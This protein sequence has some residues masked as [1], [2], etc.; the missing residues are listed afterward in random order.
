[1]TENNDGLVELPDGTRIPDRRK[2]PKPRVLQR[3]AAEPLASIAIG[4]TLAVLAW[5]TITS[6]TRNAQEA[7]NASINAQAASENAQAARNLSELIKAAQ[8]GLARI[9][10]ASRKTTFN[11]H[12][13]MQDTLVCIL[14]IQPENRTPP[15]IASCV[16][17]LSP[18]P[19]DHTV[20][21]GD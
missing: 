21:K 2:Q 13:A 7:R 1:M 16:K 14:A 19:A 17:P 20:N 6:N 18:P 5:G 3:I 10:D 12:Q 8:E 9:G 4:L 15:N 11:T